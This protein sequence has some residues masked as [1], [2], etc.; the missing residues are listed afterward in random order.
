MQTYISRLT[1]EEIE[2]LTDKNKEYIARIKNAVTRMRLLIDSLLLFSRTNRV[3]SMFEMADLNLLLDNAKIDLAQS[4]EQKGLSL[5]SAS[6]PTVK[7]IPFQIQQLFANLISNSIKYSR[8]E[9]PL[10]INIECEKVNG[11]DLPAIKHANNRR[12]YKLAVE[13]NGI[14]FEPQYADQIFTLFQRLHH[15][16]EYEGTGI[17]LSICK[18]IAENHG[19]FISAEGRPGDG[20]TFYIYLP[21]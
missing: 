4:I 17:G 13:D 2:P 5:T 12:Y 8:A 14:G 21:A 7:V 3:E 20:S 15:D 1:A 9:V 10:R 6:L 16:E 19:G 11:K 18:K